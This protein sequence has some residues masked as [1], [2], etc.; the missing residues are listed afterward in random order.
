MPPYSP[1]RFNPRARE[2]ATCKACQVQSQQFQAGFSMN[3]VTNP[4]VPAPSFFATG[5]VQ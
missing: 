3:D 2:G 5:T 1:V 4:R